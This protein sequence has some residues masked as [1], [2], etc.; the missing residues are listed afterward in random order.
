VCYLG[1]P[2]VGRVHSLKQQQP[3]PLVLQDGMGVQSQAQGA[4]GSKDTKKV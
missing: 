1:V 4:G 3:F 2:H